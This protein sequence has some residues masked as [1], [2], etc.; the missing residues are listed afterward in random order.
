MAK[1]CR[2]VLRSVGVGDGSPSRGLLRWTT[3]AVTL[4]LCGG[5]ATAL[6]VAGRHTALL[7]ERA[8][9]AADF[10]LIVSATLVVFSAAAALFANPDTYA[11][12]G[13]RLRR[14]AVLRQGPRFR[15]LDPDAVVDAPALAA[16]LRARRAYWLA[17]IAESRFTERAGFAYASQWWVALVPMTFVLPSLVNN[18]AMRAKLP[19]LLPLTGLFLCVQFA[20]M[21]VPAFIGRRRLNRLAQSLHDRVCADCG[22]SLDDAPDAS[23]AHIGQVPGL[24]PRRC[25]ECGAPWPLLPPPIINQGRK[26]QTPAPPPAARPPHSSPAGSHPPTR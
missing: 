22:Y 9:T 15:R 19:S 14:E 24:G 11:R 25:T 21:F 17:R 23:I 12:L 5:V 1:S 8:M 3:I 13:V 20:A 4:L 26:H 18:A 6:F 16:D 7:V 10:L 2:A